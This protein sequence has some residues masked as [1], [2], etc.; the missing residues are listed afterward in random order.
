M[1]LRQGEKFLPADVCN[2]SAGGVCLKMD[3]PNLLPGHNVEITFDLTD[4]LKDIALTGR[5]V[6]INALRSI[7]GVEFTNRFSPA[8]QTLRS[9]LNPS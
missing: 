3:N 2:L 9:F 6:W 1:V 8:H 7:V 4:Y 5:I